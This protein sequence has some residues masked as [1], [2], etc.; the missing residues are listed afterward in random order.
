MEDI[1]SSNLTLPTKN[2]RYGLE[3]LCKGMFFPH[4]IIIIIIIIIIIMH[5]FKLKCKFLQNDS[6][7][8]MVW[9]DLSHS[10]INSLTNLLVELIGT[11]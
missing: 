6:F 2:V 5:I 3:V 7:M 9:K 8:S 10:I 1:K 4:P 11:N